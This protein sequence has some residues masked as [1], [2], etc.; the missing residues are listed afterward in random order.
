MLRSWIRRQL[1]HTARRVT[2]LFRPALVVLEER[3]V[4][5]RVGDVF[6]IDIENHNF[7]QPNGNVNTGDS[8]SKRRSVV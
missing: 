8:I 3:T 5:T 7:T 2:R 1:T 6:Y 4:P